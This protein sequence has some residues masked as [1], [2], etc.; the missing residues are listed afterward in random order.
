MFLAEV[1]ARADA[2]SSSD[3]WRE[4]AYEGEYIHPATRKPITLNKE[5][6]E[7]WLSHF[8]HLKGKNHKIPVVKQH[9]LDP[10]Q[11]LG[12]L[13]DAKIVEEN[14]K[15]AFWVKL[16]YK[17]AETEKAVALASLSV[18]AAEDHLESD[19]AEFK[20]GLV[21]IG[22]TDYPVLRGLRNVLTASS[23]IFAHDLEP[24]GISPQPL[25]ET[26]AL[27]ENFVKETGFK[28]EAEILSYYKDAKKVV[29]AAKT[30]AEEAVKKAV[31]SRKSRV[32]A[33]SDDSIKTKLLKF[34]TKESVESGNDELFELAISG[35]EKSSD[36]DF[37]SYDQNF[38][39]KDE[40]HG[41]DLCS[42]IDKYYAKKE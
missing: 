15:A 38:S 29:E 26:M 4:L 37:L 27:S 41:N 36:S 10:T 40:K 18:G 35:Y 13:E 7:G 39:S 22:I 17:D 28:T 30:Q 11:R 9:S 42:F 8:N 23:V 31:D 5:K 1:N 25:E 24:F 12:T 6:F 16:S 32:E 34:C 3:G 33:L 2:A 21:H 14:G 19:G 20:Y